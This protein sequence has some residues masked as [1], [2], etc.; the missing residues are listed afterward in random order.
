MVWQLLIYR[1]PANPSRARVAVWRDLRR[2]GALPLQQSVAAVPELGD[3]GERLDAIESRIGAEGGSSY[4]FRLD[5]LT[6]EQ[7]R[8]LESEWNGLRSQELD[9]KSVV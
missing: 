9:R 6:P 3:L 4:R 1:L 7:E 5:D 2:L 8:G